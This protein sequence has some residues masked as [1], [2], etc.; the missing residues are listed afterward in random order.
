MTC[1]LTNGRLLNECSLG[2]AGIKTIYFT[3]FNDFAALSGITES[4][5]EITSLGLSALTVYQFDV[6]NNVGSFEEVTNTAKDNGVSFITQTVTLTLFN[7]LPADLAGLNALKKGRWAV[8]AL[9]F[10]NKM[11]LF[12][13]ETGMTATGGSDVSGAAPGDKKGLDLILT[14]TADNFAPFM[15]DYT[16][17]PFDNFANVTVITGAFSVEYQA[18]YNAFTSKPAGAVAA[19]QNLMVQ[20]LISA[21]AWAKLD[22]L[23]IFAAHTNGASEALINWINPGTNDAT[24][25][26]APT[27]TAYE[28]LQGN[29]STQY[30]NLNFNLNSDGVNYTQDDACIFCYIRNNVQE[31]TFDLGGYDGTNRTMMRGRGTADQVFNAVN[32]S[33]GNTSNCLDSRGLILTERTASNAIEHYRNNVSLGTGSNVSTGKP[34]VDIYACGQNNNGSPGNHS[35]RQISV[36]GFGGL[37]TSAQRLALMNAIETYMDSNGKGVIT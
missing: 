29:G 33:A 23:Y 11:R 28:G 9:D 3:K 1:D 10:E 4:G 25:P 5:G 6:A 32:Q 18:I 14:A 2:R 24:L 22:A 12:G 35:T 16:T 37:L 27:F 30:A 7:I 36:I 31:D 34:N 17:T 26:V 21:G 8:W 15:A 19:A 20:S 13:R